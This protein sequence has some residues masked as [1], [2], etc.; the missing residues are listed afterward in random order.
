MGAIDFERDLADAVAILAQLG[1]DGVAALGAFGM[2]NFE[3]LHGLGTMLHLFSE[4]VELEIE[5]G[6]LLLDGGE[7][8]SEDEA[9]LGAHFLT[10]AGVAL[11]LACLPL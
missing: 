5:F 7:L 6:A 9:Q 10:Q 4:G 11:G 2:F 3:L 1:F 8:A